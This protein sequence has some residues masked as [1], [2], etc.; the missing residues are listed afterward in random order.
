MKTKVPANIQK[1]MRKK[2]TGVK[3]VSLT[4][5][6]Y[7]TAQIEEK[8]GVDFI[9]VGDSMAMAVL[10]EESTQSADLEVML[11]HTK[12]VR[13]GAPDSLVI[14][15][16]PC[17]TYEDS[18]RQ[19]VET[20][21]RFTEYAGADAVKLEGGD[22]DSISRVKAIVEAGIPVM[23]HI[24]LQPQTAHKT[25]GYRVIK[26]PERERM[27]SESLAL[28]KVGTFA[29]VLESIEE[30]IAQEITTLVDVPPIGIGAG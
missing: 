13:K 12:A 23:G 3:I 4:A 22:E 20:A 1:L 11:V 16:M 30:Q 14:G 18:D 9:L 8:A 10:G 25:G 7:I 6:D 19:A 5:Y 29:I 15:D 24:G 26:L 17:G 2:E 27:L 28:Q 21:K